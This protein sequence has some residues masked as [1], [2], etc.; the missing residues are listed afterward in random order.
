M[1]Y[2]VDIK[3]YW[4]KQRKINEML[5]IEDRYRTCCNCWHIRAGTIMLGI[6]EL[7]LVSIIFSGIVRQLKWKTIE[8]T[9]CSKK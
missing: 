3:S 8:Q 6:I 5:K 7:V 1:Q 2:N 4:L 9:I